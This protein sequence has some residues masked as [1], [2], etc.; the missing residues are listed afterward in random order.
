M[1]GG[2]KVHEQIDQAISNH[3]KLLLI[4]SPSSMNSEWVKTEISRA[5][6]RETKEDRRV[7]FPISLCPFEAIRE[8]ECFDPDTGKDS[9]R[10]IREY[11]I[12]VFADWN[13]RHPYQI[14][15]EQLLRDLQ[16]QTSTSE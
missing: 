16:G 8:W 10:E 12:P 15:F 4:L 7:L 1:R 14:A 13:N 5:R 11:H 9:A 6:K 3:D 2:K